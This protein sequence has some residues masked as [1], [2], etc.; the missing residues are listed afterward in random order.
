MTMKRIESSYARFDHAHLLDGVFI[1]TNGIKRG[2]LFVP[3]RTFDDIEVSF[4]GYE[5]LGVDDQNV[6]LAVVAQMGIDGSGA[7][8]DA[9]IGSEL[10]KKIFAE[11]YD[12]ESRIAAVRTSLRAIA[13][14]AGYGT[15]GVDLKIVH[16][17][18]HRLG[19]TIVREVGVYKDGKRIDRRC[20]LVSSTIDLDTKDVIVA[21]NPR[22]TR[23]ICGM[24]R[25]SK[26]SLIERNALK[27]EVAKIL[28]AWLSAVIRPGATL[29]RDGVLIDTLL[30]HVWGSQEV[31]API[32]SNRRARIRDALVEI[33]QRTRWHIDLSRHFVYIARPKTVPRTESIV[34]ETPPA[35]NDSD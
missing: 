16:K 15:G 22:M 4:Y 12:D 29:G 5:Q 23:S 27:S 20:M 30:P 33:A 17:C 25:Y 28:H 6:F 26:I 24:Q 14:D 21:A 19:C 32:R 13:V 3:P 8:R 34:A 9:P 11:S 31:S 10:R 18:L 7:T 35:A 2:R 1:P